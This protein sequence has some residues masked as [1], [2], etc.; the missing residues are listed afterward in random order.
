MAEFRDTGD[1][2]EEGEGEGERREPFRYVGVGFTSDSSRGSSSSNGDA[3]SGEEYREEGSLVGEAAQHSFRMT[4]RCRE[5]GRDMGMISTFKERFL[6]P[7]YSILKT[8]IR[9]GFA[10]A[11][12][13]PQCQTVI[14]FFSAH[15]YVLL[16]LVCF[17][18][19]Y[20]VLRTFV[21]PVIVQFTA[22]NGGDVSALP[23]LT[24][25]YFMASETVL[26]LQVSLSL[27]QG[28]V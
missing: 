21:E 22:A 19:R 14:V 23:L 20:V 1:L 3:E 13:V 11:C 8:C 26:P 25:A 15:I 7:L 16:I 4:S 24:Q 2:E 27:S 17:I 28:Q 18:S 5:G 9:S 12:R 10:R 6:Y